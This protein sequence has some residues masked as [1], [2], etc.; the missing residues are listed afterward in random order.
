VKIFFAA[1]VL[2]ILSYTDFL[3][4]QTRFI[5][6]YLVFNWTL[7][8]R[9]SPTGKK[10]VKSGKTLKSIEAIK[11]MSREQP[12]ANIAQKIHKNKAEERGK[13]RGDWKVQ[14][15]KPANRR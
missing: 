1:F 6:I 10:S 7:T 12:L 14:T 11:S 9:F 3:K 2:G 15:T 4:Y 5:F 13:P 8:G